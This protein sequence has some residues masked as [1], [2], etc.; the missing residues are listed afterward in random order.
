M[1]NK[2]VTGWWNPDIHAGPS[3]KKFHYT[4]DGVRSLCGRY[5][6]RFVPDEAFDNT[7]HE[8]PDN[9]ATCARKYKE[10][11]HGRTDDASST[12]LAPCQ[13]VS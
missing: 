2:V 4:A 5:Y 8:H 7:M 13:V 11:G 9:C 1:E 10:K 12:N 3:R 6:A